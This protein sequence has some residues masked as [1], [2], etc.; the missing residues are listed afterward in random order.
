M[1]RNSALWCALALVIVNLAGCGGG[2][3][4]VT[5]SNNLTT[6]PAAAGSPTVV[7]ISPGAPAGKTPDCGAAWVAALDNLSKISPAQKVDEIQIVSWND[8]E[9][10]TQIEAGVDNCVSITPT[11]TDTT[12]SWQATGNTAAVDHYVVFMSPDG[13]NVTSVANV[14]TATNTLDLTP[15]N[16]T[17]GSTYTF[18]VQAVG[19]PSVLNKM[20]S[21]V[22]YRRSS[23]NPPTV[24]LS[25]TPATGA[26]PLS[27]VASVTASAATGKSISSDSIDFGDGTVAKAASASH[28]YTSAGRYTVTATATDSARLSATT[29]ATVTVAAAN[30]SPVAKLSVTPTSGTAPL[31]V[32]ASTAGSSD[33]DGTIAST[34]IDFG[35]GTVLNAASG[36]HTYNTA[37]T[38]TVK[39]T[40]TDNGGLSSAATVTVTVA[41]ANQPPVAKLTVTPTSGTAPLTVNASTA[42]SSDPDG[43]IAS[44]KIDFGDGT[45]VNAASG[46]HTYNTAGT[47]TV[48][49]TVTDNG[50]LS[51]AA[52]V[53]V[54]VAAANQPS[55]ISLSITE[56]TYHF[57]VIP[58]SVRR[59]Y[60]TVANGTTNGVNWSV[61]GGASLSRTSGPWVD[62]T[63]PASGASCQINDLGG[64]SYSV[65]S[66]KTFTVTATSQ[67][68]ATKSATITVNV[69]NPAVEVSVVPFYTTLYAGQKADVQAFVW[70]SV[71]RNVRWAITSQPA[72]GDGAL[73][74]SD[75]QDAVFSATVAGRYTLTATSVAD[76]S[77]TNTATVYVTGHAMPY[78]VTPAKTMPVD[79]TVDPQMTGKAYEVGP[80]QAYKRV[81][82]VPWSTLAAG[83]TV[84]VHNEDTT[85]TNPTT[86][87]EYFQVAV[88][89]QRT[90]PIR[91][92]GV[93]DA[94][95]NLP[96]IDASNATG[97]SDTSVYAAGYAPVFLGATGWAGLYTGAAYGGPQYLIVEGL[98]VQNATG[99]LHLHDAVGD[100]RNDLGWRSGMC[101]RAARGR[102]RRARHGPLQ[103]RQWN[104]Q[105]LQLWERIRHQCQL[106]MG[107]Q[108]PPCQREDGSYGSHQLYIQGLNQVAQFNVIDQYNSKAYGSNFKTRGFPDVIR[109][110]HFGDGAARQL[111]MIDNEDAGAYTSF[112]GYLA[113]G[114]NSYKALGPVDVYPMDKIAATMEVH[115]ADYVYGNTFVNSRIGRS[116]PLHQRPSR[117]GS[118]EG[119]RL[120]TL[121]FYN[122]SFYEP[123]CNNCGNW[124]WSLFDTSSGGGNDAALIEWPQIQVLNNAFWFDD[125]TKPYFYWNDKSTAFLTFGKNAINANWGTNNMAGGDGTGWASGTG[126]YDFQG[127]S[128]AAD[129]AGVTNLVTVSAAPFDKTTFAPGAALAGTGQSLPAGVASLPVRFQ[130]GPSATP[131]VRSQPL[132]TGASE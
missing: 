9:K 116:H 96:V 92:C 89:A 32:S 125:P 3:T 85:G 34:K 84:R 16:L 87:H 20:S 72:G 37:G 74:D 11:V 59:I 118:L 55:L 129:V 122:N 71:N 93:P 123:V 60:A 103:L 131:T 18:F 51:S 21:P 28:T 127:A 91:V 35:D 101:S 52:T 40:V 88:Q 86:Y 13:E 15:L 110:N 130:F 63:A 107:R 1:R 115:H 22:Q 43:T 61:S 39:A 121:W 56:P 53:T 90:Q 64:G 8:Y 23:N 81:Q 57:N 111:D 26:A 104:I 108:S 12:L 25:I 36:S 114:T 94:K 69:C 80:S 46:S 132:T 78:A 33:P 42:G 48:K 100:C 120:G 41:A 124:R 47:Y 83:S 45:V 128:N 113:G 82:D 68:D 77:K 73:V 44:T 5:P 65:T 112:N 97:R 17:E 62:V 27:T 119:S 30:Q 76:G 66:A 79:C 29:T 105:R 4:S 6:T 10:G 98:R 31:T 24:T 19:R 70:G 117:P 109:Y 58:G 102:L 38:Y 14:P 67:E 54:T 7:N 106:V 50:G 95:G 2:G 75:K 99:T 49:A 126:Q